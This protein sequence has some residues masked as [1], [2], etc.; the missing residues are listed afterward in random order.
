MATG[1]PLHAITV[2]SKCGSSGVQIEASRR[3]LLGVDSIFGSGSEK[4]DDPLPAAG[5]H[6]QN[7]AYTGRVGVGESRVQIFKRGLDVRVLV[8]PDPFLLEKV[9]RAMADS[10]GDFCDLVVGGR[11]KFSEEDWTFRVFLDEDSIGE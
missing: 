10:L 5:P 2:K 4:S 1:Q 6:G 7:P 8:R 9:D 3:S 11:R